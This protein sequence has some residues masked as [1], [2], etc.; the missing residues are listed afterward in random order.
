MDT[1]AVEV[2]LLKKKPCG[3]AAAAKCANC[4]MALCGKH[5]VAQMNERRMKTGK[6]M[7][8]ECDKAQRAYDKSMGDAPSAPAAAPAKGAPDAK[9]AAAKPAAP[10]KAPAAPAAKAPAAPVAKT[11]AVPAKAPAGKEQPPAAK[12][13]DDADDPLEFNPTKK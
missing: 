11:P 6:F 2:G 9:P 13:H 8:P 4:E 7:C 1:C 5:A 10:A 12:P 3:Q